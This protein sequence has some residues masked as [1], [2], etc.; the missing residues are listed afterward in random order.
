MLVSEKS[1]GLTAMFVTVK[2][3]WPSLVMVTVRP[4]LVEF[5]TVAGNTRSL[6]EN[7]T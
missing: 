6:G 7:C 1:I 2:G 3:T 5:I 4:L